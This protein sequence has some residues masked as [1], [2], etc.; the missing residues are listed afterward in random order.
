MGEN[1]KKTGSAAAAHS[2]VG[3]SAESIGQAAGDVWKVLSERGG[4]TIAGLKKALDAP[5]E[6]VM[7][8]IGWLAREDKLAFETSGRSVTVSLV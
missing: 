3:L 5:D 6:L 2:K 1:N 8:A 7:S 4:Q